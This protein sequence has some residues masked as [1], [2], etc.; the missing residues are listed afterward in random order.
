MKVFRNIYFLKN[1]LTQGLGDTDVL[2]YGTM[3]SN[4]K[5]IK[6]FNKL[7][8]KN[9]DLIVSCNK[10]ASKKYRYFIQVKKP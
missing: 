9:Q 3:Y 1:I 7:Y 6:D 2:Y 10:C 5:D 4:A 8:D